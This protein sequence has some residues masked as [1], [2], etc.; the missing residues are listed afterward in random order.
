MNKKNAENKKFI[1]NERKRTHRTKR[2][3][4][5]NGNERENESFL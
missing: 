4:K 1:F 3:F 2:S 5:M